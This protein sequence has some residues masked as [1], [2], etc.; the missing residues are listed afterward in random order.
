MTIT[1]IFLCCNNM[2]STDV[3][4]IVFLGEAKTVSASFVDFYDIPR[5]IREHEALYFEVGE[6]GVHH[7]AIT[8]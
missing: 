2:D 6:N 8:D 5:H 1:N 4:E 3:Y 7:F